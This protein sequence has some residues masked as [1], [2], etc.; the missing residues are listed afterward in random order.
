MLR[1]AII[2][3]LSYCAFLFFFVF[4]V[5]PVS[6]NITT[7][8]EQARA[9]Q[10]YTL[11]CECSSSNPEAEIIWLHNSQR[12]QGNNLALMNGSNGGKITINILEIVP[13]PDDHMAVYGC[14][15][16]N[17]AV[18]KAINDGITLDILCKLKNSLSNL[19]GSI[20]VIFFYIGLCNF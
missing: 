14:R 2:T 17:H 13:T 5:P 19:A 4:Q 7:K 18:V 10:K 20:F 8:P 6:V 11:T 3:I 12:L 15:A 9:G 16:T 1:K